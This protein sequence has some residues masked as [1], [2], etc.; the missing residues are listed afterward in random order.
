MGKDDGKRHGVEDLHELFCTEYIK[1]LNATQAYIRA[2]YEPAAAAQCASRLLTNANVKRRVKELMDTRAKAVMV[3]A[4]IVLAELLLIAKA[5]VALAYNED[6]SLKMVHEMPED[7]R[8]AIS[9][10]EVD[11]LFEGTGRDRKQIGFTKRIKFWDKNK[12]LESIGRHLKLFTDKHE[13]N[14]TVRLEDIVA[15]GDDSGNE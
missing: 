15:G 2:G 3:D 9:A 1:D 13:V 10:I 7:I 8:R 4:A 6:G 12:A 11:E 14:V 5:D